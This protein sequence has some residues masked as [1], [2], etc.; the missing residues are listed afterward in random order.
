M[1]IHVIRSG[2]TLYSIARR[3]AV[4]T[5]ELADANQL[6][7]PDLLS[8]GQALL[9][10]DAARRYTVRSG[11]TMYA[12]ARRFELP[13]RAL[14]AAN[15]Q[16]QNPDRIY[17]GQVLQLP[18]AQSPGRR[19]LVNGYYT[20]GP[21]SALRAAL[22]WLSFL[23]LFCWTVGGD[24]SLT[25]TANFNTAAAGEYGAGNLLTVTNLRPGGG[26]SSDIAH[27]LLTDAQVQDA[28]FA[29]LE[30]LLA[31]GAFYGVNL[32]LEYVYPFDRESYNQFLARLVERM[33]RL[34]RIVVTALAP[35][36]SAA[37]QGLLY[38][39]HDYPFHGRTADY[40][41]L[42]TYE[43]GYTYGPAMAVAPLN[44]VKRVLDY[45]VSVMPPEKLLLG[46]PNYGYNWTLPFV[47]GSRAQALSS[48]AAVALAVRS[49]APIRFDETAQAP[50][51]RYTDTQGRQHEV[52]FEDA[53]S[54]RAKMELVERYGLAGLS[55]WNIDR[56]YRPNYL[57]LGGLYQVEK[58]L[59]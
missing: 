42:M 58:P 1:L 10:P 22:P 7:Y 6:Q 49:G 41:V 32:D 12:I 30:A 56:L 51:F 14:I 24:G 5:E 44:M 52:W 19:I 2:D 20:G 53:R 57:V 34:G 9:I 29:N 37:Q 39:A 27:A 38:S 15:P 55:F 23:S 13:L 8:V 35:K 46:I 47:Q 11:D 54:L 28:F 16:I 43:W 17:P 50:F 59:S 45:A 26:F 33:H 40:V 4:T 31:G 36:T 18:P 21:E 48:D 3:F 25:P